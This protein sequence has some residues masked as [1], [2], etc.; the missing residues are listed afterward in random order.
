MKELSV[1]VDLIN[2]YV[3][4]MTEAEKYAADEAIKVLKEKLNPKEDD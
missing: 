3:T 2:V 4:R 1:L